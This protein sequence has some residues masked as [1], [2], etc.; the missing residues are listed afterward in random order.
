M[1]DVTSFLRSEPVT[2]DELELHD[3]VVPVWPAGPEWP[4][5]YVVELDKV[6]RIVTL[7]TLDAYTVGLSRPREPVVLTEAQWN[8]RGASRNQWLRLPGLR[9]AFERQ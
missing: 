2:F 5:Q 6:A 7:V 8:E 1:T 9:E 4:P 3:F